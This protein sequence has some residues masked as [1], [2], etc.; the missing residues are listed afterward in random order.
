MNM[1]FKKH[2]RQ[3][4]LVVFGATGTSFNPHFK[5]DHI[6]VIQAILA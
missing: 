1:S 6:D 3:Y 5:E 2:D 4:D